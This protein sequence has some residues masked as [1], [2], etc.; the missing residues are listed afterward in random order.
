MFGAAQMRPDK[1]DDPHCQSDLYNQME[2][3]K[4]LVKTGVGVP[5]FPQLHAHVGQA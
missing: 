3:V 1:A 5:I 2:A 4:S